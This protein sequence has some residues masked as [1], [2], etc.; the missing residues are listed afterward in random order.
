MHIIIIII[1]AWP[2]L[3]G[4][5][6]VVI[7]WCSLAIISHSLLIIFILSMLKSVI[8]DLKLF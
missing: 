5:V 7:Y 2:S 4:V 3:Q 6:F 1:Q 8:Q